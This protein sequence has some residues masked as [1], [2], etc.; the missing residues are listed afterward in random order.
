MERSEASIVSWNFY[1]CPTNVRHAESTLHSSALQIRILRL[2]N[3]DSYFVFV[4][5][6]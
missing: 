5:K 6:G 3:G 2:K 1:S 4:E